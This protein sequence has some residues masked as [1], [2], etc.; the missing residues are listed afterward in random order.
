MAVEDICRL[1]A[2]RLLQ[3][4]MYHEQ[5]ANYYNFLGLL[6]Y[7]TYHEFQFYEQNN[8]YKEFLTY[9]INHY[10]KLIPN[11]FSSDS[12]LTSFS[13]IPTNWYEYKRDDMD[14]NTRRNAV[15]SGLEKYVRWET[16]TKK[17]F[18]DMYNQ[19][20]QIGEVALGLK[21]KCFIENVDKEI[22]KAQKEYLEIKATDYDLPTIVTKQHYYCQKYDKKLKKMRK[23]FE[24]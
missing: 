13:I 17:F 19:S 5:F 20:T 18:E 1:I 14:N 16:Q 8:N 3:G 12:S 4:T 7:K 21:V 15:K 11:A 9:F 6:G 22:E 24:H 23:E 2:Q 10:D